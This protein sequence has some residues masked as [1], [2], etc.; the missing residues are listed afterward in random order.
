MVF[1][2]DSSTAVFRLQRGGS[3]G[4]HMLVNEK[5]VKSL[6]GIAAVLAVIAGLWW[7]GTTSRNVI[8]EQ[9]IVDATLDPSTHGVFT[10]YSKKELLQLEAMIL[11]K[12]DCTSPAWKNLG[13][14]VYAVAT[15]G[16]SVD[17]AKQLHRGM[18]TV[19]LRP[20][21]GSNGVFVTLIDGDP[22]L[23]VKYGP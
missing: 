20:H 13:T 15:Q 7:R 16:H 5:L 4:D 21:P 11:R 23:W 8:S 22:N 10:V 1:K 9:F 17:Y 19:M 6:F 12:V 18:N 2:E 14:S 3:P